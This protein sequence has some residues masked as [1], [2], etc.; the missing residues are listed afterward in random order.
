MSNIKRD[1]RTNLAMKA[2][3]F[4][5]KREVS[6]IISD[7]SISGAQL[8]INPQPHFKN[9]LILSELIDIDD[10]IDFSVYELHFD[11][12]TKIVR[13][14]IL[15]DKL[16]LS[17]TLGDIFYGLENLAYR[18]EVYRTNYRMSGVVILNGQSYEAISHNV[19]V[20]GMNAAIFKK[21]NV[22]N[23]DEVTLN[24]YNLEINGKARI[25][26]HKNEEDKTLLGI[27][28]AQ[29]MEPVKGVA[30]FRRGES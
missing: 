27:E 12:K 8:E 11:G 7:I 16:F 21:I 6:C 25:I 28:Y 22:T 30:S 10:V 2:L 26:W 3:I 15:E 14:Q 1:Y 29:L 18:R 19:S 17:I 13:K 23:G 24:F 20:N 4:L 5:D 9:A